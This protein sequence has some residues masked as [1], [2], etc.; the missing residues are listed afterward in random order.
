MLYK[1]RRDVLDI[2]QKC[3]E[4]KDVD[5]IR[6]NGYY[7][8]FRPICSAQETV[9]TIKGQQILMLGSNSYLGLTNDPR[10]KEAAIKAV[11]K[12]GTGCAGSRFLNGTLDIHEE[13]EAKLAKFVNKEAALLYS[14][15]YMVNQGVI[16][17]IS[18]KD[19][20]LILDNLDHASIFEGSRLTLAKTY[21]FKHNDMEDLEEKLRNSGDKGKLVVVD[22]I[23]S[24]EGDI[25]KLPEI[26]KL[27]G[28]YGARVMV[29]DAH[30]LGVLG[31]NGRGT[32][33]HFNLDKETDLIMGTFSKSLASLG[34]FIAGPAKVIDYLRHNS[35]TLIFHASPTPAAVG[36]ALASLEIMEKEPERIEKLWHNTR[37][38]L[39]AFRELGFDIGVA[40][41]PIIPVVIGD[42]MKCFEFWR[43]LTN[44]ENIFVNPVVHP[45]V[46]HGRALIRTSYMA[47]H[48]D[49]Q[50]DQVITAFK[51]IGKSLGII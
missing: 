48:T 19:D 15:G 13:L 30:S 29:D 12:Y 42:D 27:C 39:K 7:A 24:M 26:V 11:E 16:S 50:L 25:A 18:G 35:R 14:T 46:P 40:E 3:H 37:K 43:R 22:G 8:Y 41:T 23:F 10:V 1:R 2:F 9:V 32:A 21:R 47:T 45:A 33:N 31:K 4:Y 34:G 44:E 38:M 20:V 5:H 36:A 6:E 28:K 51:K 17:Y 49:A